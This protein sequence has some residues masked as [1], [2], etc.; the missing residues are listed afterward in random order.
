M[1]EKAWQAHSTSQS[2]WSGITFSYHDQ[3][4]MWKSEV[5]CKRGK[6]DKS[7]MDGLEERSRTQAWVSESG[8]HLPGLSQWFEDKII[9][10][11]QDDMPEEE[12]GTFFPD[13]CPLEEDELCNLIERSKHEYVSCKHLLLARLHLFRIPT[14]LL[15]VCEPELGDSSRV[16][17]RGTQ[18]KFHLEKLQTTSCVS[19]TM[20]TRSI[21]D[22]YSL[23]S[24]FI[25]KV[26]C[27]TWRKL[28]QEQLHDILVSVTLCLRKVYLALR[29]NCND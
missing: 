14:S 8:L 24:P 28:R 15:E 27:E 12:Y 11:M 21:H 5:A 16:A 4:L 13:R 3:R 9:E 23:F 17:V 20:I 19:T 6:T 18:Y 22:H 2:R 26:I 1:W 29:R 7:R 25:P 10:K